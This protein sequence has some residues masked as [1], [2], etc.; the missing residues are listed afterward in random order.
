MTKQL[1]RAAAI[2]VGG[3]LCG[4]HSPSHSVDSVSFELGTGNKSRMARLGLQ[5]AW[6]GKWWQSGGSHVGGYSDLT[7]AHWHGNRSQDIP[8]NTQNLLAIGL[9]PVF[10]LQSNS[11][12]G[13]YAEVGI[14]AHY[15]SELYDNN[16]RKFSTKFQFGEHI[17][18][19]Y[20]FQNNLDL[21]LKIQHL[22][23]GSI[24][25]PNPG[26]NFAIIRAS[27]PF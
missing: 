8:G 2:V 25:N 9:T 3:I 1:T 21:G 20:V 26:V 27:H 24:K 13:W 12:K 5:W 7:L 22:S 11:L 19:G 23:N 14:G 6:G 4:L 10:R 16:G 15:L 18:V 17:G